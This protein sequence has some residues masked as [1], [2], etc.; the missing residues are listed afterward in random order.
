[1]PRVVNM[2]TNVQTAEVSLVRRGANNKRIALT[3][4]EDN[5][6]IQ[7]LMASVLAEPAEG[8]DKLVATLK[9][10][11][12]DEDAIEV[13]KANFRIQTGFKDKLDAKALSEVTKA[14]GLTPAAKAK[15]EDDEDEDE[16]N[17]FKGKKKQ[18]KKSHVPADMPAE[19]KKAF[20]DQADELTELRKEA[21]V[22][23]ARLEKIEKAAEHREYLVRCE[24]SYSH[25]PGMSASEQADT[26]VEAY[27]VSKEFGEKLEKQWTQ[28]NESM[29]KSALLASQGV[30]NVVDGS[31]A[32]AWAQMQ[33]LAKELVQKD[34]NLS[35]AQAIDQVMKSNP[36]LY[37]EYLNE[38]P[39]Q[40][41]RR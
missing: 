7:E 30:V 5:M 12:A 19:L 13:A 11:G 14:A 27:A 26:L 22:K 38:N 34:A 35:E 24:K 1:M 3:K 15:K 23:D 29:K 17:P 2:L 41:G 31:A 6:N 28:T 37:R 10:A 33:T 20:D 4:S 36:E 40:Q 21:A 32:G 39:A 25:V 18:A 8:E 16:G 9:A